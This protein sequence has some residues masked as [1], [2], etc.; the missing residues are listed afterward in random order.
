[1]QDFYKYLKRGKSKSVALQQ[2]KLDFL[3]KADN[4]KANPYFWSTYVIIGN[5]DALYTAKIKFVYWISAILL[6]SAIA[7]AFFV[8]RKKKKQVEG[9]FKSDT[10][11][12]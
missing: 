7:L 6:L 12:S 10:I 9:D 4:L 5:P 3:T 2:A 1:M 11:L 8:R